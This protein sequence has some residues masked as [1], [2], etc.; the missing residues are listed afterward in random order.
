MADAL[1]GHT[2]FVGSTLS[3]NHEFSGR[4][5]STNF[6]TMEG[7]KFDLV[8]CAG[9]AAE[10]WRAN[11]DP[12][13]DW[14]RIAELLNVLDTISACDFILISTIDVYPQ[15]SKGGDESTAID[16]GQNHAYG[17]NRFLL[18]EWCT[19][20]FPGARI[21]RLPALFGQG[22]KK[23]ALFDL[24]NGNQVDKINPAAVFQWYPVSRLWKDIEVA[25]QHDLGVVNLFTEPLAMGDIIQSYFGQAE[26]GK[27]TLPAPSYRV[28]TRYAGLFG[29]SNGYILRADSCLAEIGRY[30]SAQH[31]AAAP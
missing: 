20:R 31:E 6:R 10:K 8:V 3:R 21:V 11:Q 30:V 1:I 18:E 23:N 24:I 13:G 14:T 4:F 16:P 15:P 9:I 2:G 12:D 5:N 26:V 25:R 22:L 29:G 28:A 27:P 17:R 7:G 19:T